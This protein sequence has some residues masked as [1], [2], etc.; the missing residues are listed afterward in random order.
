[1]LYTG[2]LHSTSLIRC[3]GLLVFPSGE[4]EHKVLAVGVTTYLPYNTVRP[5]KMAV[6]CS[7]LLTLRPVL[8]TVLLQHMPHAYHHGSTGRTQLR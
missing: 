5:H 6:P 3:A 4:S 7:R 8:A 1:M 2:D